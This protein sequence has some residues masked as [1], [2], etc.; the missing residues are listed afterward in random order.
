[1]H[2]YDRALNGK[3]LQ[4][5]QF[6]LNIAQASFFE[7]FD[8][9]VDILTRTIG[10]RTR[11]VYFYRHFGQ[12]VLDSTKLS[13]GR[14]KL[15]PL[16]GITNGIVNHLFGSPNGGSTQLDTAN[17]EDI[18]GNFEPI[19]PIRQQVFDR[20]HT[21]VKENLTSIRAFNAHF[22]LRLIHRDATK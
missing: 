14:I 8:H 11:S 19:S 6:S 9:V 20:H 16:I 18:Y 17:V 12:F 4:S 13:N 15:L 1:M 5:L 3:L 10:S 22:M 21:V 7:V 2:F